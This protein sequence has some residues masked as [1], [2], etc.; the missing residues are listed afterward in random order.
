MRVGKHVAVALNLFFSS[1]VKSF[2]VRV[3]RKI[4]LNDT[5]S[6]VQQDTPESGQ[7]VII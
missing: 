6:T 2:F 5:M 3:T 4:E 1:T 7:R